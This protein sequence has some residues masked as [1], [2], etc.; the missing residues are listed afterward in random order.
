[1]MR[2]SRG[3][4]VMIEWCVAIFVFASDLPA[5]RSEAIQG[6]CTNSWTASSNIHHRDDV[7]D[8]V[9]QFC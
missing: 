2:L 5:G 4:G 6:Q 8:V 1:M 9:V 3:L 7:R